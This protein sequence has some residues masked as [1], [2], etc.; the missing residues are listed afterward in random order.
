MCVE[1]SRILK[2]ILPRFKTSDQ[3][4]IR[5]LEESTYT[6]TIWIRLE[7]AENVHFYFS[8]CTNRRTYSKRYSMMVKISGQ[9]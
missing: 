3:T 7:S 8:S 4:C 9:P 6:G 2:G 5:K 1:T